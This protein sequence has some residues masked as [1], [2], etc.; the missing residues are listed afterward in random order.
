MFN[1][2][3]GAWLL[4]AHWISNYNSTIA[5]IN[6]MVVSALVT[7]FSFVKGNIKWRAVQSVAG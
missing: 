7:G 4:V 1:V 5:I 6:N 3:V 2:L